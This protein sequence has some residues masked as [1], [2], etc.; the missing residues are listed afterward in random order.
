MNRALLDHFRCPEQF[1]EI[2]VCGNVSKDSGFFQFGDGVICF[3]QAAGCVPSK[4]ITP[5]LPDV[6]QAIQ[7]EGDRLCFPFDLSQ[8][9]ENLQH[10]RYN[11]NLRDSFQRRAWENISRSIYYFVRPLLPVAVRKHLQKIY[12][13]DRKNISFPHWPVDFTVESLM[14]RSLGLILKHR[15]LEKIPFI[16]FWPDGARGG[17]MMTHDVETAVGRD[18]CGQ[19]MDLDDSSGIKSSFQIIPEGRYASSE[20]FLN[21]FRAKDFEVNVHDFNHDG[22]LFLNKQEFLRRAAQ[23]NQYLKKMKTRGFRSGA[24]YRRQEWYDAFECSY[25]M[26]VPNVAHLEPQVGGSCAVK[27]YFIGKILELPLTTVQDY[28]L[29]HILDDY[30]IDL[31]KQQIES[32][33]QRNGLISFIVHPDYVI[34]ERARDVYIELL[35]YLARLREESNLWIALPAEIDRWWRNRNEMKLVPDGDSWRIE[36][37][38]KDRARVAYAS[39]KGDRVVYTLDGVPGGHT[40]AGVDR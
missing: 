13:R 12:F 25:D 11:Q 35:A 28:T 14:E 37:P 34:G 7:F 15:R 21:S 9:V 40:G 33:L 38:D 27:P 1:A 18:F 2:G 23:I 32:L 8:V 30:S 29:F 36:G 24:M 6:S 3:G 20:E 4:Q 39:L 31:W 22:R 17:A 5:N 19:L 16:W 10:E 26:S